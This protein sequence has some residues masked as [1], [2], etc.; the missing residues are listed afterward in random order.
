MSRDELEKKIPRRLLREKNE[1]N[2]T[3]GEKVN[4]RGWLGLIIFVFEF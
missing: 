3:K 2:K 1:R 4:K